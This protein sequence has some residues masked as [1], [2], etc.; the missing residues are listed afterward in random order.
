MTKAQ[1]F[2]INPVEPGEDASFLEHVY[3]MC[4][5]QDQWFER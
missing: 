4:F 3:E 2:T 1:Y 5:Q